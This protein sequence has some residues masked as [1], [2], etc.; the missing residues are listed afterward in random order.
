MGKPTPTVRRYEFVACVAGGQA[1]TKLELRN[2]KEVDA[3][4]ITYK[5]DPEVLHIETS[6]LYYEKGPDGEPIKDKLVLITDEI[7]YDRNEV[8]NRWRRTEM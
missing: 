5:A 8:D 1:K 2:K 3:A 4:L 6:A 7:Y